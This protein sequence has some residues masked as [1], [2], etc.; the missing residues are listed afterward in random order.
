MMALGLAMLAFEHSSERWKGASYLVR[1]VSRF[2][3]E[4]S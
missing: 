1:T 4:G 2:L 3:D